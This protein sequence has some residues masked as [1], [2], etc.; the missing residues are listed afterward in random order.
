MSFQAALNVAKEVK[1]AI[2]LPALNKLL[3]RDTFISAVHQRWL[4]FCALCHE[5]AT[6]SHQIMDRRLFPDDGYYLGNGIALCEHHYK[7]AQATVITVEQLRAH[8]KIDVLIMPPGL[9]PNTRYDRWGNIVVS[10]SMI[11]VGPLHDE[12]VMHRALLAARK[13]DIL[14]QA[15][16]FMINEIVDRT[17]PKV[18]KHAMTIQAQA[19][20][21]RAELIK[22]ERAA[23]T[24]SSMP[25]DIV[26]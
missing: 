2:T 20:R 21:E 17:P 12:P 10:D 23:A 13:G 18:S 6:I 19:R 3:S 9:K 25:L 5:Q 24:T 15:M 14:Y 11:I 1:K 16:P 7:L 4:G 8:G 22:A 26:I